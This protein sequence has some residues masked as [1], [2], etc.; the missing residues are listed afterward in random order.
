MPIRL[1][2][3]M[4]MAAWLM[5]SSQ[6]APMAIAGEEASAK[7]PWLGEFVGSSIPGYVVRSSFVVD[8]SGTAKIQKGVTTQV[9]TDLVAHCKSDGGLALINYRST[10]TIGR[11]PYPSGDGK[12]S[13][14]D[15]GIFMQGTG[16]CVDKVEA[17]KD[18][19]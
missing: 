11:V 2:L 16:D 10:I 19:R 1:L 14:I 13:V 17:L 12:A 3:W 7:K 6:S 9:I 18:A 15:P 4:T 8:I 5:V